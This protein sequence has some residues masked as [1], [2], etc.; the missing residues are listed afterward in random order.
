MPLLDCG[1]NF[2]IPNAQI[3][4]HGITTY[5]QRVSVTC[6]KGYKM[7]GEGFITCQSDG[8][9]SKT[10]SC[11]VISKLTLQEEIVIEQVVRLGECV[12]IYHL[13]HT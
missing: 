4:Y 12:S 2:S 6:N 9:W 8:S 5:N 1:S 10:A 13:S 7:H 11:R 3:H